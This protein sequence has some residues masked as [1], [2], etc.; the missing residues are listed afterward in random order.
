M[1]NQNMREEI[2]IS[3]GLQLGHTTIDQSEV[4]DVVEK[5][6]SLQENSKVSVMYTECELKRYTRKLAG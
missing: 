2:A 5:P 4:R 3:D 1:V 6:D